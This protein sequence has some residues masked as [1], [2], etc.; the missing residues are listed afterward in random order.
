M[1]TRVVLTG[2]AHLF[3]FTPGAS[4]PGFDI[5]PLL[6]AAGVLVVLTPPLAFN[7][8]SHVVSK[9]HTFYCRCPASPHLLLPLCGAAEKPRPFKTACETSLDQAPT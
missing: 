8:S 6:Y 7:G 4:V 2:L 9:A 5:A 3:H 1:R